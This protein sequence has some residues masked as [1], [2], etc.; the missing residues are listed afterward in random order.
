[1]PRGYRQMCPIARTL[2][3]IGERWTMLILR[4]MFLGAT[5]FKDFLQSSPSMPTRVLSDRLK[6]LEAAGLARREIYSEHPLRAEYRLTPLGLTL[7]PVLEELFRW[8][9]RHQLT[10]RERRTV[11]RH[12]YGEAVAPD[13][14]PERL[15]LPIATSR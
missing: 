4:D 1:V 15:R 3:L 7:Q 11:I 14:D 13:A 2:D 9:L 10:T 8:G 12:L 5:K 6:A